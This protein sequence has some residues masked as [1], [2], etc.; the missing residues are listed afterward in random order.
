ME[1]LKVLVIDDNQLQLAILEGTLAKLFPGAT[2][3]AAQT[4]QEGLEAAALHDPDVVLLDILMPGM[5]GYAVCRRLKNSGRMR[6]IPVLFLTAFDAGSP[7]HVK[8]LQAGAEGFLCKPHDP[9]ELRTE[10]LALAR[11]K[12]TRVRNRQLREEL[13]EEMEEHHRAEHAL[14][15]NSML[16]QSPCWL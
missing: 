12:A 4:G 15:K 6:D 9:Q 1:N 16:N 2:L 10:I 8:A 11:M 14:I 13:G 5:N 7:S 3:L